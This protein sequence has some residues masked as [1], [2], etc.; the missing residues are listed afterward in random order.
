MVA[1]IPHLSLFGPLDVSPQHRSCQVGV[2]WVSPTPPCKCCCGAGLSTLCMCACAWSAYAACRVACR[3][4]IGRAHSGDA[5]D[6]DDHGFSLG[7]TSSVL[8][9][10]VT[11]NKKSNK[12][13]NPQQHSSWGTADRATSGNKTET[14]HAAKRC[15]VAGCMRVRECACVHTDCV[16]V[17]AQ[18]HSTSDTCVRRRRTS[19]IWHM[20]PHPATINVTSATAHRHAHTPQHEAH[21]KNTHTRAR[22]MHTEHARR[23]LR[24]APL[25]GTATHPPRATRRLRCE[26]H[27]AA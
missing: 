15:V 9:P 22:H 23:Q 3:V 7:T 5:H 26:H 4:A 27:T 21:S 19:A 11:A 12:N 8:S 17:P 1:A 10:P 24:Y 20:H 16:R 25:A 13:E 14:K 2:T 6:G 18:A